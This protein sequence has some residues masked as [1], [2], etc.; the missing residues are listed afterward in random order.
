MTK[1]MD[2][3]NSARLYVIAQFVLLADLIVAPAATD[4]W[5]DLHDTFA[6]IGLVLFTLGVLLVFGS[7]IGLG[8]SLTAIP[9]PKDSGQLVVTGF[10]KWLRHPIYSGLITLSLGIV[11]VNGYWP[12]AIIWFVLALVLARKSR[13]EEHF[14]LQKYP[15]YSSYKQKTGG[16]LPKLIIRK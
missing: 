7:G 13:F 2:A 14:L 11:L 1:Y 15:E 10:Y 5:G 16:F 8:K 4:C 3:R 12:Q 6:V 9:L